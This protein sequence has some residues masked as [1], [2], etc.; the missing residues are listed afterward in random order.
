MENASD[1]L[2]ERLCVT[3]EDLGDDSQDSE[4]ESTIGTASGRDD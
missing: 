1:S 3:S 2:R 4:H